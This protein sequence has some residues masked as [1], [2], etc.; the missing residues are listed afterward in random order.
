MILTFAQYHTLIATSPCA[1]RDQVTSRTNFDTM[2]AHYYI[3]ILLYKRLIV[4]SGPNKEGKVF[5]QWT[6]L[7]ENCVAD[8][9]RYNPAL[10]ITSMTGLEEIAA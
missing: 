8:Y 5:Y 9:E 4:A 10:K 2:M 6:E 3:A 7:G 1:T